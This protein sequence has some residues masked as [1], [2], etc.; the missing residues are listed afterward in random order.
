MKKNNI[1]MLVVGIFVFMVTSC[2]NETQSITTSPPAP[3]PTP[4]ITEK[5]TTS[6]LTESL[7]RKIGTYEVK[8]YA[9]PLYGCSILYPSTWKRSIQATDHTIITFQSPDSFTNI[10]LCIYPGLSMNIERYI[11]INSNTFR[12]MDIG[13]K[14]ISRTKSSNTQ[15]GDY[16][17]LKSNYMF[18][19]ISL[20]EKDLW[21]KKTDTI[22]SVNCIAVQSE[23]DGYNLLFD[24]VMDSFRFMK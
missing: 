6:I 9:H 13:Y 15:Y 4:T 10:K 3:Q 17:V 22:F 21:L 20:I 1:I 24:G 11:E 12:F 23:F 14:E 5:P 18:K 2:S 8:E 7:I 19:T 16:I